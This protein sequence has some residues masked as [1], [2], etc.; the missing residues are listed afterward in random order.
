[1]KQQFHPYR[2]AM[3]IAMVVLLALI[4]AVGFFRIDLT[5]A[6]FSILG[7]DI[8]WSNFLFTLGLAVTLATAPILTYMTIGTVWCG[9][10]CP[11]NFLSEWANN[12]THKFL[13]KRASVDINEDL[14]VASSKNK[15]LNW[16]ILGLI[17][18]AA[19][20][21]LGAIPFLFFYP[22][23]EVWGFVTH[24][25]SDRI[26]TFMQSLY[27][28]SVF[29]TFVNIA[30]MRHFV[31]DYVCLYRIGQ[32]LFG[33]RDALHINYDASRSDDCAKCNYC[34]TQCVTGIN[35]TH[36][37]L[38]DPCINC[39]ECVDACNQLHAKSNTAGLIKFEL[40]EKNETPTLRNQIRDVFSRFNWVVGGLF[41]LGC[42]MMAW[43]IV[44]QQPVQQQTT[45]PEE[46]QKMQQIARVCNSQCA[47]VQATCRSDNIIGCAEASACRCKCFL[48]Q[49]P[50]NPSRG[51]WQQCAQRY[52]VGA[53]EQ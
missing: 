31:C 52:N 5:T 45:S 30:V 3:Q 25:S 48:Q 53:K 22:L 8:W 50:L 46:Q 4:P 14:Q 28:F 33:T 18:L 20:L 15:P 42:A 40:G 26:S 10:L 23:A 29:L 27:Y 47:K 19:S 38:Y 6:T 49:D 2:R 41:L 44:T 16:V 21:V 9:W 35:P 32:R 34:S 17:F 24:T 39:G 36:I 37:K 51:E 12:M 13:G 43:G 1:M 7:R 11:Q